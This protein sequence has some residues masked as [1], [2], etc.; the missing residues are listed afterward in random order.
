MVK[1]SELSAGV[2]ML[3]AGA[4]SAPL[5]AAV[6]DAFG[7]PTTVE[8]VGYNGEAME[9]FVTRDGQYLLFNNR[10]GPTDQTDLFVAIRASET[11]FVLMGPLVGA[12]SAW[13][14][15]AASV[16]RSGGFFF[17]SNRAYDSLGTTLWG[18]RFANGLVSQVAPLVTN[19][20][21]KQPL[22][23][24]IDMEISADGQTLYVAENRWD[25]LLGRP[26]T[27]HLAMA[28]RVGAQFVRRPDSDLL[29]RAINGNFLD[30]APASSAD[31][32]TLYFTRW[33]TSAPGDTGLSLMV[34][35]RLSRRAAWGQPQRIMAAVGHVEGPSV[36]PDGCGLYYHALVG[37][38]FRVMLTRK[39]RC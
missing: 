28:T 2:A 11:R 14:D 33:D 36:T 35:H 39:A 25:L 23:L 20:T 13:L 26:A 9:P 22:R 8:I 15:G 1:W 30:Y 37:G 32:L 38:H 4:Q 17:I 12:N 5:S 34:S 7:V 24:N 18:G 29:M 21:P 10:N 16:D 31:E 3:A 27:S 19:F 6:T